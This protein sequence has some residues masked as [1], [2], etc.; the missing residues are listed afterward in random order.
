MRNHSRLKR[1]GVT[2]VELL[3]V[4]SIIAIVSAML[5]PAIQMIREA[6]RKS[7]CANNLRQLAYALQNYESTYGVLPI[8]EGGR[9]DNWMTE[10]L[11][12]IEQPEVYNQVKGIDHSRTYKANAIPAAQALIKQFICPSNPYGDRIEEVGGLAGEVAAKTSY[13]G[14]SGINYLTGDGVFLFEESIAFSE[15]TD[16]LSNTLLVGE[17][18]APLLGYYGTWLFSGSTPRLAAGH[19]TLGVRE[20]VDLV[21]SDRSC[22]STFRIFSRGNRANNCHGLHFWSYHADG[23]HFCFVDGSV[24]FLNYSGEFQLIQMSTRHGGE[25]QGSL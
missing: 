7:E 24:K 21:G 23:A 17:R 18:P 20:T 2:L 9:G 15:I 13:V 12:Y 4:V 19:T 16:G 1:R 10:V 14:S 3:A 11:P 25:R 5:L 8:G 22:D 6:A